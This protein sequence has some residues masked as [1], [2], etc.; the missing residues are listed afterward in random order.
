MSDFALGLSIFL[1]IILSPV[2]VAMVITGVQMVWEKAWQRGYDTAWERAVH[3]QDN[4][5]RLI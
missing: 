3:A 4:G 5:I 2:A 1:A